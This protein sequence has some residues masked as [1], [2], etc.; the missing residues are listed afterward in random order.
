[1]KNNQNNNSL[2][3][4]SSE[5]EIDIKPI[6]NTLNRERKLLIGIPLLTSFFVAIFSLFEL[7]VWRGNFQIVISDSSSQNKTLNGLD[8]N[9]S[10]LLGSKSGGLD[11]V[12]QEIILKSPSVLNPVYKYVVDKKKLSREIYL[13]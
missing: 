9:F 6:I 8:I 2:N 3:K 12:T 11:I 7:P 1:M 10:K 4:K 13:F 5:D